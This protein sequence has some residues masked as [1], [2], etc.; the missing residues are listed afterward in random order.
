MKGVSLVLC[1]AVFHAVVTASYAE[2]EAK[3]NETPN[4][5]QF[6]RGDGKQTQ[7]LTATQPQC[8]D[9]NG[10]PI[11]WYSAFKFSNGYEYAIFEESQGMHMSQNDLNSSSK[12][13][14]SATTAQLF[15]ADPNQIS[16]VAYNDEPGNSGSSAYGHTKGFLA[17]N[18]NGGFWMIHSVPNWPVPDS[19]GQY[20][21]FP[22]DE[23]IYSQSFLCM[24]L[25]F[26]DFDK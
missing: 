22:E 21:G 2:L 6:L 8:L 26:E 25:D 5:P 17:F 1:A 19:W 18:S 3:E 23:T 15:G 16:Y 14:I 20:K 12:G 4:M 11:D 10:Q 24:T 13:A 9:D 7:K